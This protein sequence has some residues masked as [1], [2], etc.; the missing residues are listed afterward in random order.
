MLPGFNFNLYSS[1]YPQQERWGGYAA[2]EHKIC[3]DQLRLFGDFF[4]VDAKTHD[5]LA[6]D[7]TGNFITPGSPTR[8]IPP[9]HPFAIPTIRPLVVFT[10]AQVGMPDDAFN[11][12]NPFEQIISGGTR[13]RLL[14]FGN[15]LFDNEN[16]AERFTVGVKG[17]KLFNGTW[18]Y[19]GAFMYSQIEQIE[20][21]QVS[22]GGRVNRIM[23]ANDPLFD[24]GSSQ[25]IGQTTPYNPFGDSRSVDLREQSSAD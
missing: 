24:P 17:D 16:I 11:P 20:K 14:D 4:Y 1:S 22:D 18:G 6:P 10:P 8:Y 5:E 25:Y 19:D 23:N 15:R 12:F 21:A 3:D 2:F 9:N 13:A 7:A